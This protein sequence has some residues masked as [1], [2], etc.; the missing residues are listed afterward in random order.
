VGR[1]DQVKNAA[2]CLA[3]QDMRQRG[4]DHLDTP[5]GSAGWTEPKARQLDEEAWAEAI[6]KH[7]RLREI[8]REYEEARAALE[9]VQESYKKLPE[10]RFYLR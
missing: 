6:A 9:R 2:L 1:L 10:S 4:L 8:Q 7:P 5:V 3:E